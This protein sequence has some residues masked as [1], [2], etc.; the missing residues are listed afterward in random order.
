MTIQPTSPTQ[1]PSLNSI[2]PTSSPQPRE[3][4]SF[5]SPSLVPSTS[6]PISEPHLQPS[7]SPSLRPS[8]YQ[9][10]F[11]PSVSPVV[12]LSERPSAFS[13]LLSILSAIFSSDGLQI[14]VTFSAPTNMLELSAGMSFACGKVLVFSDANSYFCQWYNASQAIIRDTTKSSLWVGSKIKL[15][16][17]KNGNALKISCS[18]AMPWSLCPNTVVDP[19]VFVT[20]AGPRAPIIPSIGSFVTSR[21]SNCS[22]W[23][24]DLS[25]GSVVTGNAGR[26]WRSATFHVQGLTYNSNISAIT[27]ELN[28][29][30]A[31]P[32]S[33]LVIANSYLTSGETYLVSVTLCNFLNACASKDL[34]TTVYDSPNSLPPIVS[35]TGGDVSRSIF[36][37]ESLLLTAD[38]YLLQCH[39]KTS[40]SGLSYLWRIKL[41]S[42]ASWLTVRSQS[43]DEKK[44]FLAAYSLSTDMTYLAQ[45]TV[46]DKASSLSTSVNVSIAIRSADLVAVISLPSPQQ[47]RIGSRGLLL[48]ASSSYD[49]NTMGK[50]PATRLFFLWTC[51]SWSVRGILLPSC[52]LIVQSASMGGSSLATSAVKVSATNE[53]SVGSISVVSVTVYDASKPSRK[54]STARTEVTVIASAAPLLSMFPSSS[55]IV[56]SLAYVNIDRGVTLTSTVLSPVYRCNASWSVND[57]SLDI[58]KMISSAYPKSVLANHLTYVNLHLS[59]FSLVGGSTYT[60]SLSCQTI[61]DARSSGRRLASLD[62]SVNSSVSIQVS[63]NNPPTGGRLSVSPSSGYALN[64]SFMIS[65]DMWVDTD[66]PLSYTF[67]FLSSTSGGASNVFLPLKTKSAMNRITAILASANGVDKG[68]N[69][70]VI[71]ED[72]YNASSGRVQA[73]VHI[74]PVSSSSLSS[75]ASSL[76]SQKNGMSVDELQNVI[77]AV[78]TVVNVVDCSAAPNC[79]SLHRDSCQSTANTCGACY[80]SYL[81]TGSDGDDNSV[82]LSQSALTASSSGHSSCT[83]SSSCA[84]WQ[85][86]NASSLCSDSSKACVS[87]TCSSHGTCRYLSSYT[88]QMVNSC[89]LISSSCEAVCK[90]VDGYGGADCSLTSAELSA[91]Q[92]LRSQLLDGLSTV[93]S[94][95]D[96][97]ASSLANAATSLSSIVRD[98]YDVSVS[99]SSQVANLAQQIINQAAQVGSGGSIALNIS[100]LLNPIDSAISAVV[101]S[102]SN[103]SAGA[104][105][106][107]SAVIFSFQDLLIKEKQSYSAVYD[108]FRLTT[109]T[110][111]NA[112]E[113]SITVP[114]ALTQQEQIE[115]SL[116]GSSSIPS[117]TVTSKQNTTGGVYVSVVL[118]DQQAYGN[119][120]AS[121]Q[122][123]S[124]VITIRT[125]GVDY[126]DI[127]LSPSSTA[128][129]S[130][131]HYSITCPANLVVTKN[132][133]CPD[134]GTVMFA[135][136]NGTAGT[137]NG[138]CP[139]LMQTCASLGLIS[140]SGPSSSSSTGKQQCY[141]TN[142]TRPSSTSSFL[143]CRCVIMNSAVD[144]TVAAGLVLQYVGSDISRT[145]RATSAAFSSASAFMLYGVLR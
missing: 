79:T 3:P 14:F 91:Q 45:V 46:K 24:L 58:E 44:F 13:S 17:L 135:R 64:T 122:L 133:T 101:S 84:S 57:R 120:N 132:F 56:S 110:Y 125:K 83:S 126:I 102:G 48:N 119:K 112:A 20:I 67:S 10:S 82:C 54:N 38:A 96:G 143:T 7:F 117:V 11:Q 137:Y 99:S 6:C 42:S 81:S 131:I 30:F 12:Q 87:P 145:F 40:I 97:D 21:I 75:S 52:S 4:I 9:P 19:E 68:T 32:S 5:S 105:K 8:T 139:M 85:Y 69:V 78:T 1:S 37:N 22:S 71:A 66:L 86:C 34:T 60:F 51:R 130:A 95:S 100:T 138:T 98:Q 114:M 113:T 43:K 27:R 26:S 80:T 90:C 140:G 104:L 18:S 49:P 129:Y 92:A 2:T 76:L 118:L 108:T 25:V 77:S 29:Q 39:G 111:D 93:V 70:S 15:A 109:V 55:D 59:A 47:V 53:S 116:G 36:V 134:S 74:I 103:S 50:V 73:K 35:I 33:L 65:T 63:T 61:S 16:D 121:Q 41:A 127:T 94:K 124:D 28:I 23:Q 141:T 31:L 142:S 123:N 115:K 88:S 89:S 72:A 107:V 62:T 144:S 128:T 106:N 136:C